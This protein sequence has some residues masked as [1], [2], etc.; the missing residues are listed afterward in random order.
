MTDKTLEET[1]FPSPVQP[2]KLSLDDIIQFHCHKEITCFNVC[3][4][5]IDITL[6]PYD[7]LRLKKRLG[8]TSSEFLAQYTVPFEMDSQGM[9]GV[10]L[11]TADDNPSC[12]FLTEEGCGLYEDRPTACRYYALGLLSMRRE[13]AS[14]DEDAY[15]LVEEDHCLGHQEP[16]TIS[17]GDYRQEQGVDYYDKMNRAWRQIILKKR[18]SGPAVGTPTVR[19]YQF[20]FLVCYNLDDFRAFVQSSGFSNVYDLDTQLLEQLN[21][22]DEALLTFGFRLLKQV[23]FGEMTIPVLR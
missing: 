4:K 18:S 5:Q 6:T 8:L 7:I 11:R 19:S 13:N 9:P 21:T 22:D 12:L 23:L 1:I 15:F 10:K 17:V 14:E 16:R 2:V 20:F 3:C